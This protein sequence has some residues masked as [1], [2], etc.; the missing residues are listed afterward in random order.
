METNLTWEYLE[1]HFHVWQLT[2]I[3]SDLELQ[4]AEQLITHNYMTSICHS[5][6]PG[7]CASFKGVLKEK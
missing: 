1:R 5:K 4:K 3:E 7:L 6:M 2:I